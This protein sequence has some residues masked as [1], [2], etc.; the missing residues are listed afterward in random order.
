MRVIAGS[1][2]GR[3]FAAP[4][5]TVTRPTSDR[6]R[7]SMFSAVGSRVDLVDAVVV[8]LFAGSGALGIEALSRGAAHATF[9]ERDRGALRALR[10]N[11]DELGIADRSTVVASDAVVWGRTHGGHADVLFADPPYGFDGWDELLADLD[12][13]LVVA[14]SDD[15][16]SSSGWAIV[17][18]RRYGAAYVTMLAP[19]ADPDAGGVV[20]EH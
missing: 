1:L 8:D 10:R 11:L 7:E 3:R 5:G 9:V 12:A 15:E 13:D 18:G 6:V 16:V 2:R 4:E 17:R 20:V 19:A 14:E